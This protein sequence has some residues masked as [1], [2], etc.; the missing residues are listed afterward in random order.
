MSEVQN[1]E[2][3]RETYEV[4]VEPM[5]FE[6]DFSG[7]YISSSD[8]C[9]LTNKYFHVCF[10]DYVGSK[11][12]MVNGGAPTISLYFNHV[13]HVDGNVY[14]VE[15]ATDKI[16]GNTIIDRTRSRDHQLKEGDRYHITED[17]KDIIKKLLIPRSFNQGNPNWKNIVTDIQDRNVGSIYAPQQPQQVTQIAGIDPSRICALLWG[18][19]EGESYIDY[20]VNVMANLTF[21]PNGMIPGY[22]NANYALMITKAYNGQLQKTYEKFGISAGGSDIIR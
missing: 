1:N 17:G 14:A 9:K 4:K 13:E 5:A 2:S 3:K 12:I 11:F 22:Q 18:S 10:A 15:R 6:E 8:L 7:K 16:V 21:N 20:G 19:K